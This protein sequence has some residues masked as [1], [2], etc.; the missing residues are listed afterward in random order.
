MIHR[1]NMSSRFIS[2]FYGELEADGNLIYVNA[3]HPPPLIFSSR[4]SDGPTIELTPA[5]P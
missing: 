3:G 5:A 2:V 1:S 4:L